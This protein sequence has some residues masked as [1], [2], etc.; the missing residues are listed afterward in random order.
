MS[1]ELITA[2]Y[3]QKL[4]A[5]SGF[6]LLHGFLRNNWNLTH[7]MANNFTAFTHASLSVLFAGSYLLSR[8]FEYSGAENLYKVCRIVSTGYF[9]YDIVHIITHG[10]RTKLN[11]L[12]LYHHLAST[13]LIQQ[14]PVIYR[15]AEVLFWGE[16]SNLPMY[17][18]Y[19]HI[20]SKSNKAIIDFWKTTQA[21]GYTAIRLPILSYVTYDALSN[22]EDRF[23]IY[24]CLPVYFM[25][26]FWSINL[27]K[28]LA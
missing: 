10:K 16:L 6:N 1:F 26:I 20:K 24:T 2:N 17:M 4:M 23:P 15:C 27:C 12:Y 11:L 19:Y 14:N 8:Q 9:S 3:G 22:V 25:G 7:S 13:Y 28:K 5:F 21:V 18:V